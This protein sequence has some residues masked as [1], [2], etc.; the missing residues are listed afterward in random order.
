MSEDYDADA[1]IESLRDSYFEAATEKL[2]EM[3]EIV[4]IHRDGGDADGA[5]MHNL[6]RQ[7]H[8]LKGT[9]G[10]FGFPVITVICHRLEEYF[11]EERQYSEQELDGGQ[12]YLDRIRQI[13]EEK[14]NPDDAESE[15]I[16][17][18]LPM[19]A[20]VTNEI[21][22]EAVRTT[23]VLVSPMA[24]MRKLAEFYLSEN[25]CEVFATSSSLEAFS[26]M[27]AHRP[28]MLVT[29]VQ[30]E[31]LNGIDLGRA[32]KAVSS[33]KGT[34][35]VLMTSSADAGALYGGVPADFSC[36]KTNQ[37]EDDISELLGKC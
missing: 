10:T 20:G 13:V 31:T 25:H 30:M 15:R 19:H 8:S 7:L 35:V 36:V 29:S 23:V 16:L 18:D 21:A 14:R 24:A 2:N 32:V 12:I 11:V 26:L 22:E 1:I 37:L 5:L 34:K 17:A 28:D 4:G 27:L 6:R 33:L 3:D 9:S